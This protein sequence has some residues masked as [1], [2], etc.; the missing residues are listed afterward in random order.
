MILDHPVWQKNHLERV[1]K[2]YYV[3]T[4]DRNYQRFVQRFYPAVKGCEILRPAGYMIEN[5]VREKEYGISFV[6]TYTDY[7]TFLPMIKNSK[8]LMRYV[9]AYFLKHMK[10]E[11][12]RP[13][14]QV[15]K[16]TLDFYGI[17]LDDMAFL[18]LFFQMKQIVYCVMSYYREKVIGA[19]LDAGIRLHVFGESWKKS[20]YA[21]R[22]NLICHPEV[23]GEEAIEVMAK[24][25][26]SLNIMS[27]HKDGFTE[28][29]AN[30]MLAQ[31]VVLTDSSAFL[32]EQFRDGEEIVF[33]ELE[34]LQE[35][36]EKV[37]E[38]LRDKK[39]Q[40]SITTR[41]YERALQEH[42]WDVRAKEFLN[43]IEKVRK[44]M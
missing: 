23:R 33:F 42:T 36:P 26:I 3:L 13:A 17:V 20:P 5:D 29:I 21:W 15:L 30:A 41:A 7:R 4:H 32:K 31:S 8:G 9:A 10:Q 18:E 34:R 40:K 14:E 1:P 16:E 39:W 22:K 19:L 38:L 44:G 25:E 6:G 43:I 11:S 24:S 2:D 12:D 27:W 37:R 35:L 28:R